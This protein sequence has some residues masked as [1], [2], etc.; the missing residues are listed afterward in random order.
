MGEAFLK[1]DSNDCP[2]CEIFEHLSNWAFYC[3][4]QQNRGGL[5]REIGSI[6]DLTAFTGKASNL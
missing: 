5:S 4:F 3:C 1:R 6:G 2:E